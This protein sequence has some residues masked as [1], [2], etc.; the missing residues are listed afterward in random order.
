[1]VDPRRQ[2]DGRKHEGDFSGGLAVG[3]AAD[4]VRHSRS[5]CRRTAR[6]TETALRKRCVFAGLASDHG[7]TCAYEASTGACVCNSPTHTHRAI[8]VDS[9][10]IS[11]EDFK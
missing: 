4:D 9:S 6:E 10:A 8:W 11:S 2:R 1:A 5:N 7:E 3:G